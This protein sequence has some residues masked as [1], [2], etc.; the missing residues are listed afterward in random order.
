[1]HMNVRFGLRNDA[2]L[3][4]RAYVSQ[5]VRVSLYVYA[6]VVVRVGVFMFILCCSIYASLR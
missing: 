5:R 4:V 3:Y 2:C 1:M 6:S